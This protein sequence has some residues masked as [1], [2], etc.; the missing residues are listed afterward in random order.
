MGVSGEGR[1][2][3]IKVAQKLDMMGIG[4]AHQKDPNGIA[5]KQNKDYENLLKRLNE[6]NGI[7]EEE[8]TGT[9]VDG[10]VKPQGDVDEEMG[11][12]E[13]ER[14]RKRRKKEKKERKEKEGKNKREKREKKEREREGKGKETKDKEKKRK[15]EDDEGSSKKKKKKNHDE[16]ALES[17]VVDSKPTSPEPTPLTGQKSTRV[18]PR[19]RSH[20]ARHIAAK[21]IGSKSAAAISEILGIAPSPSLS[22]SAVPS[23]TQTPQEGKL[24]SIYD[25]NDDT[26]D[27]DKITTSTK[28][29]QDYFK[30]KMGKLKG[31][32]TAVTSLQSETKRVVD[33]YDGVLRGG[34]G[35]RPGPMVDED[36]APRIGLSKFSALVSSS[37]MAATSLSSMLDATETESGAPKEEGPSETTEK[38]EEDKEER[39]RRKKEKKAL[40]ASLKE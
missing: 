37:F 27:I 25:D 6:A 1:T 20:R 21:S 38:T 31:L 16:P 9:V 28:S 32:A 18:I 17:S 24:T 7:V 10:F 33:D 30:E 39:R 3:H 26:T 4:A 11:E 13:K 23:G 29:L 14:E 19:H 8:Q 35:S 2:T 34:I 36:D 22:S 15:R 5:W 40:S 12:D